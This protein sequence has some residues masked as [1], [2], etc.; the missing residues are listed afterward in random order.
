MAFIVDNSKLVKRFLQNFEK[1]LKYADHSFSVFHYF[2]NKSFSLFV[3]N[4]HEFI[5]MIS[6]CILKS[7]PRIKVLM[8]EVL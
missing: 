6:P 2:E 8:I 7:F 4:I 5:F 1:M 3:I